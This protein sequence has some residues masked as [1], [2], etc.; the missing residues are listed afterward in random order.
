LFKPL[1]YRDPAK[2][3]VIWDGLDWVGVPEAW[4]T[5]PE[6]VRLRRD[7]KMFEGFSAVRAGSATISATGG[8]PL[9]ARQAFVSANFFQLLGTGPEI[10]RGFGAGDDQPGAA[11]IVVISRKL[12]IQTFGADTSLIGKTIRL[13]GVARTV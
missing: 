13:D 6:I 5:G 10:G 2:L 9:Q 4:L 12:W 8:E 11:P 3:L 1:P 7:T